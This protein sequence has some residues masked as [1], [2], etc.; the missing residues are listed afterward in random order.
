MTPKKRKRE[1]EKLPPL[2]PIEKAQSALVHA[3]EA[4]AETP[5][6]WKK[7]REVS[8]LFVEAIMK[9]ISQRG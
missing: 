5:M 1:L 9:A 6:L 3:Q 2:P 7:Q 8:D 4:Y